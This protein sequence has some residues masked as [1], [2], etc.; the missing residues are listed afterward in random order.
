MRETYLI[1]HAD[2]FGI[3]ENVNTG[4]LRAHLNGLVTSASI[5]PNGAAFEHAIELR[6]TT[7]TLDVGVHL[8]LVDET[9]VLD[10]SGVSSLVGDD[11]KLL[12]GAGAFVRKY[13]TGRIL[14]AQVEAELDAQICKVKD[15]GIDIT[16]LDGHQHLHTLPT[17]FRTVVALARKHNIAAVRIPNERLSWYMLGEVARYK[18]LAELMILKFFCH[19]AKDVNVLRPDRFAGFFYGGGL[20]KEHLRTV[21]ENLPEHGGCEL[22]CH[23][24]LPDLERR[25]QHWGYQWERE[26]E[27]L[28]DPEIVDY[29]RSRG[30]RLISFRE[31]VATGG[32][33]PR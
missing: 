27:A 11:G 16:H 22:M 31:L 6:N 26:L 13:L 20:T 33:D 25:Y 29:V 28:T 21:L 23:P 17:I 10:A 32:I 3:S 9:P 19:L 12:P 18:R 24:G 1:V 5:I 30:I 14:P 8:T 15:R 2:D 4:I 7:P